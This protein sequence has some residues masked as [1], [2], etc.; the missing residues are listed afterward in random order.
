MQGQEWKNTNRE[1][2]LGRWKHYFEELLNKE[3]TQ[4]AEEYEE[5]GNNEE[6]E[7]PTLE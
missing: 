1:E 7:V 6:T 3:L 5:K 4:A 2:V